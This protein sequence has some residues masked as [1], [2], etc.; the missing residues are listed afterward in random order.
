MDFT[1]LKSI[2]ESIAALKNDPKVTFEQKLFLKRQM[3]LVL[4]QALYFVADTLPSEEWRHFAL[5]FD[6]YTHFTSPIRRY[7]DL[8][9]HR[10]MHEILL[11]GTDAT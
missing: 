8:L 6:I 2:N 7:P 10:V 9:V 3:Y 11:H 1:N 4:E 5:N